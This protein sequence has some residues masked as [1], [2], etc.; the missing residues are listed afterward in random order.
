MQS[1]LRARSI[2]LLSLIL[3]L[4]PLQAVRADDYGKPLRHAQALLARGDYAAAYAAYHEQAQTQHNPLAA[5]SVALF[6]EYGWGR[7]VDQ[8]KACDWYRPA[9]E[10][11]VPAAAHA[12]GECLE[13]GIGRPVDDKTAA[14]WYQT[15]ARLGHFYSLCSLAR[16]QM[17]GRGVPKQPAQAVAQCRSAAER[18]SPLAMLD[19][20][21]FLLEG[22]QSVRDP[23]RALL[24]FERAARAG[25]DEAALYVGRQ[26]AEGL[27]V[28]KDPAAAA[29]WYEYLAA[30]GDPRAYLKTGCAYWQG[31]RDPST[32][33]LPAA[34][35]A[36]AYVW[37]SAAARAGADAEQR[38]QAE[39]LL[40]QVEQVMPATWKPDLD[41]KVNAYLA[42][43]RP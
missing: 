2:A 13:K 17:A 14:H 41:A 9:A 34:S 40:T 7:P 8:T 24:W 28:A 37:L 5:F 42:S 38:T 43:A 16:L 30:K 27:G 23:Q 39:K 22:D 31:P 32:G 20:G 10:G 15:A 21:R 26:Y 4:A 3:C 25:E 33:V 29:Q 11:S 19:M 18:G 12:W 6:Y 1:G 36:K 35:L